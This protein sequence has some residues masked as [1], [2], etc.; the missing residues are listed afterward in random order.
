MTLHVNSLW[1]ADLE[2]HKN[3]I[4]WKY[5]TTSDGTM[6]IFP[7]VQITPKALD[8][9]L[10]HWYESKYWRRQIRMFAHI[11]SMRV[12][13]HRAMDTEQPRNSLILTEHGPLSSLS[14]HAR[15][16]G[17]KRILLC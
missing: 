16:T 5:I 11:V 14:P 13:L 12:D 6:R 9:T 3:Y 10:R 17:R 2:N 4:L 1:S 15:S 8:P 7:G